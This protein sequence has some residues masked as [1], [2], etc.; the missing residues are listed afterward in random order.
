MSDAPRTVVI[1]LF[2]LVVCFMSVVLADDFK[3]INGKEYKDATVR[4]IEPDGIVL[5]T[6]SGISKVYFSELPGDVQKRFHYNAQQA[7]QFTAET[8]TAI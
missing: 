2:L 8:Q 4:R 5:T 7:A 1:C 3:T 6:K